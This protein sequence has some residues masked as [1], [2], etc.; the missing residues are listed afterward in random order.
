M[1]T[2]AAASSTVVAGRLA[3]SATGILVTVFAMLVVGGVVLE[4]GALVAWSAVVDRA[5]GRLRADLVDVVLAQP[6]DV[7]AEQ[8]VGELL[9]RVDDDTHQV[10]NLLRRDAWQALR[11]V[12]ALVPLW[13]VAGLT[14][15]PAFV[16]VP[17][18]L[19]AVVWVVRSRLAEISERKVVEEAAWTDHAAMVEEGIAARD[20]IRSSLGQPFVVRRT[21]ELAAEVHRRFVRVLNLEAGIGLATGLLLHALLAAV[22]VAGVL[23]VDAGRL[24][25]AELVTLFLV[26]SQLV[27][28]ADSAARRLPELQSGFGAVLRLR[29]LLASPAEPAGGA[30]LP[31]GDLD[32]SLQG[33]RFAYP[34]GDFALRDLDLEVPAGSTLALVGRTGSGKSTLVSLLSRAADPPPGTVLLGGLDIT[35]VDLATLRREVGVV[36]QRTELLAATLA[37]NITL[38]APVPRARVEAAV[39]DLGLTAWIAGLPRG[40]DTPL[41]PGGTTLSA[42]EEQL[43][44]FARLLVRDVRVV[45]LDEATARM[46]PV[47]EA[48][49]VAASS[50]LLQ[51]R[52]GVLVAHRLATTDRADLVAVMEGGRI[53]QQGPRAELAR[54]PGRF[55]DLVRAA[56]RDEQ[57]QADAASAPEIGAS[58]GIG[59]GSRREAAPPPAPVLEPT[60]SLVSATW[61]ALMVRKLWGIATVPFFLFSAATG[62]FGAA[63]AWLWGNLV[64]GLQDGADPTRLLVAVGASLLV[65]PFFLSAGI[66]LYPRWWVEV[67]LRVRNAVLVGQTRTR[68]LRRDPAGEVVGRA[69]DAD[70]YVHYCDLWVDLT[71]GALLVVLTAALAGEPLAGLVP[72]SVLLAAAGASWGGRA[73]AGRSESRASTTRAGFGRSLVS[74]LESLRTIK[75]AGATAYARGHLADVDG[76]RVEAALVE[77][78]VRALLDAVPRLMVQT[79]AV[80]AWLGLLL[81]WWGLPTALLLA[82]SIAGF[83]FFGRVAG[84]V[85]TQAPGT[86]A[87]IEATSAFGGGGQLVDLPEGVDL[88]AGAA[89]PPHPLDRTPA[90]TWQVHDL[91]AV[92]DDG[93]VGVRGVSLTLDPGQLVLLLGP[94]GSG[95]S[96]VLAALAGLVSW[97]GEVCRDGTAITDAERELR[98]PHV[99]YVAQVPRVLS[100]TFEDNVAMHHDRPVAAAL[101]AARLDEDVAD[102]GGPKARVGHRGVRL[103]GGQVQR[104]ALARALACEPDLLLAD[105][106]SSALDAAT[107]IELWDT[108]R[109]RG[110]TVL[111]STSKRAA[112][113]RADRVV[114]LDAGEVV[115]TGTWSEL[116]EEWGHLAG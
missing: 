42:G 102:A 45:V 109:A 72:A 22:A 35:E 55:A 6:L 85:V 1:S 78:R 74:V 63:T 54:T 93:T 66:W 114:V 79:G 98:P 8:A 27:G 46:D 82:S 86:R 91:T 12:A 105:D 58:T 76:G 90:A 7:A 16:L 67:L 32:I 18:G 107:E 31:D 60:P 70:R 41:G 96:S 73:V 26:F 100:G 64:A 56:A 29:E 24:G 48:R 33:L 115:G 59:S 103:S 21:A 108:L 44:A 38:W 47:T 87:W 83:E 5:E 106:V 34:T 71:N 101:S 3:E 37:E 62:A 84:A 53:V 13:V 17:L 113:A 15:T 43:V 50:R 10:G 99:A 68:R 11:T 39:A 51:G 28:Q 75:L 97:T 65:A 112:L 95:K 4:N 94:V 116:E 25:V 49:V 14:W 19:A 111:A 61:R 77:H 104:L 52:T 69:M 9:D 110:G 57:S 2:T 81:G 89:P 40:L 23:L 88:V 30:D 92:H 36:T 80:V 20:D